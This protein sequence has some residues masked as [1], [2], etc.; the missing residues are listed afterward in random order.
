MHVSI[1]LLFADL[2]HHTLDPKAVYRLTP[3]NPT[4]N[5]VVSSE[6][7]L[8]ASCGQRRW[9]TCFGAAAGCGVGMAL[10]HEPWTTS[11]LSVI[12][13]RNPLQTLEGPRFPHVFLKRTGN[14]QRFSQCKGVCM[15]GREN[16]GFSLTQAPYIVGAVL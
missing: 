12:Q 9:W 16:V 13:D 2:P 6:G 11:S 3:T 15:E 8:A 1:A 14:G 5:P 4:R 10:S 7:G